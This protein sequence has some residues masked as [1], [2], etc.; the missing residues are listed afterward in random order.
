MSNPEPQLLQG[1]QAA[2]DILRKLIHNHHLQ[3]ACSQED[4]GDGLIHLR[5]EEARLTEVFLRDCLQVDRAYDP[6][7]YWVLPIGG[8]CWIIHPQ[9]EAIGAGHYHYSSDIWEAKTLAAL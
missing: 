3:I 6:M 7:G 1:A 8:Q 5:Q 2:E 4:L 9:A